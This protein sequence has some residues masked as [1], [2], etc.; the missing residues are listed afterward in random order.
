MVDEVCPDR[1]GGVVIDRCRIDDS[2]VGVRVV[3]SNLTLKDTEFFNVATAVKGV[4]DTSIT[5]E[6]VTHDEYS[7]GDNVTPLDL[8]RKFANANV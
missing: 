6:N 1:R 4:G 3:N 2:Q 7:W 5:A 8:V